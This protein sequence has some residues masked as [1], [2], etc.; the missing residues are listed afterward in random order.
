MAKPV[1]L[2][3][4]VYPIMAAILAATIWFLLDLESVAEAILAAREG[5]GR[6]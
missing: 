3:W 4:H 6:N 1:S 5:F 2:P